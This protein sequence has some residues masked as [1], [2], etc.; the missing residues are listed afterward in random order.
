[1]NKHYLY[2]YF[3]SFSGESILQHL[4]EENS[5]LFY[6]GGVAVDEIPHKVG[7]HLFIGENDIFW[8]KD[9]CYIIW[10]IAQVDWDGLGAFKTL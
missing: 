4:P 7:V 3:F 2:F 1:M 9:G 6:V 8:T 10:L 5:C